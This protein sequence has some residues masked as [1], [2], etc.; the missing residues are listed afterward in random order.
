MINEFNNELDILSGSFFDKIDSD[1]LKHYV[2]R[3][4]YFSGIII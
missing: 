1:L 4:P 3:P 2:D